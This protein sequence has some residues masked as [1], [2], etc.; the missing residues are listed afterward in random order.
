MSTRY[1]NFARR[2]LEAYQG[3]SH[4]D[5]D[6]LFFITDTNQLFLG[7]AQFIPKDVATLQDIA[8]AL[9]TISGIAYKG[10]IGL[11][12]TVEELPTTG[13]KAGD[14][15]RVITA[16][17]YATH[18]CEVGDALFA[19]ETTD[20]ATADTWVVIQ[21]YTED[22]IKDIAA[23]RW[24]DN[25]FSSWAAVKKL[26]M[27]GKAKDYIKVGDT[28]STK[29]KSHDKTYDVDWR[30]IGID[31]D[32]KNTIT[33]EMTKTTQDEFNYSHYI[34]NLVVIDHTLSDGEKI[35]L[36][37]DGEMIY[38]G[39]M[40]SLDE[41]TILAAEDYKHVWRYTGSAA[42][43]TGGIDI[44][45]GDIICKS[46]A[47]PTKCAKVTNYSVVM[48]GGLFEIE[49]YPVVTDASVDDGFSALVSFDTLINQPMRSIEFV[50]FTKTKQ[51]YK[52]GLFA[53]CQYISSMSSRVYP[54]KTSSS[55]MVN[56]SI[57]FYTSN[58]TKHFESQSDFPAV[59]DSDSSIWYVDDSTKRWY[60][61][62]NNSGAQEYRDC[63]VFEFG[64]PACPV[65]GEGSPDY[66]ISD[67]RKVLNS[68][69]SSVFDPSTWEADETFGIF[70]HRPDHNAIEG[71]VYQL[72]NSGDENTLAFLDALATPTK[73]IFDASHDEYSGYIPALNK[74]LANADITDI[75]VYGKGNYYAMAQ[76][77]SLMLA[78]D[79]E[80]T[81]LE[82]LQAICA[83]IDD[84]T[85][86]D[87]YFKG[88]AE[89][90]EF[91]LTRGLTLFNVGD[92]T[93]PNGEVSKA[94]IEYG[95]G[96]FAGL[97]TYLPEEGVT[98]EN[99]F[100]ALQ[101]CNEWSMTP[102]A[103]LTHTK[104]FA[105]KFFAIGR[106]EICAP[107][108]NMEG[109]PYQYYA[110]NIPSPTMNR[111]EFRVK[112]DITD[113]S[114]SDHGSYYWLRSMGDNR[115]NVC[116]VNNSGD[117]YFNNPT[118]YS[119]RLAPACVIGGTEE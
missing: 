20:E 74:F 75:S 43:L 42:Q 115:V 32:G 30:V 15:Y 118:N 26:V 94:N 10:T 61:P 100:H 54:D 105:D 83:S 19:I 24:E 66:I 5:A 109:E 113:T 11:G 57:T 114:T 34:A 14:L 7:D 78:D 79:G 13:I 76:D 60:R 68:D 64:C 90:A 81:A 59:A 77:D 85:F 92:L 72:Q 17:E 117:V 12:G 71:F 73:K 51:G 44:E 69:A 93:L 106:S 80:T 56:I 35:T 89:Q 29:L 21:N 50:E 33:L 40:S 95:E 3:M 36:A 108:S 6:T 98:T 119:N 48:P 41:S 27:A 38:E 37:D 103:I 45:N 96:I 91:Y 8:E 23:P 9:E 65:C 99:A 87:T 28:F 58:D 55:A 97:V 82:K 101:L 112:K 46:K 18:A 70:D 63:G 111:N 88:N 86:A 104:T 53:G 16:G 116:Y 62:W 4:H 110:E 102:D 107:Y 22:E 52:P 2:T 25:P 49:T 47:D 31:Q 67:V 1:V 39:A 84:G